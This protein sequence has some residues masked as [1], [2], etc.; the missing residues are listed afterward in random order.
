MAMETPGSVML[1]VMTANIDIVAPRD[2][3]EGGR[4]Q[5]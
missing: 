1:M 3:A 5:S 2:T 4:D